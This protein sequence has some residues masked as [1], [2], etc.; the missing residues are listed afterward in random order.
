MPGTLI[1][2][3]TL[4]TS[5]PYRHLDDMD[6]EVGMELTTG[7]CDRAAGVLLAQACGDALGVPYEFATPPDGEPRMVGGGLGPYAPASGATTPRWRCVSRGS[8]PA[9]TSPPP[10]RRTRS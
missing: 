1:V 2:T 10:P 4:V 5:S 6:E 9:V 3:L 8:P 7:Q